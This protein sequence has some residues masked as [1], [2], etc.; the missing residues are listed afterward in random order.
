MNTDFAENKSG[1]NIFEAYCKALVNYFN[2]KGRTSRYDYWSFCLVNFLVVAF[3]FLFSLF[4]RQM[5]E[6][7]A[8][9]VLYLLNIYHLLML[10][11]GLSAIVRR[12]HDHNKSA[13]TWLLLPPLL[14]CVVLFVIGR[15]LDYKA[16]IILF[17]LVIFGLCVSLFV[18]LCLRGSEVDN[19][20]GPAII[21]T[22]DQRWKGLLIPVLVVVAPILFSFSLGVVS[23]YSRAIEKYHTNKVVPLMYDLLADAKGLKS[24][25]PIAEDDVLSWHEPSQPVGVFADSPVGG[26]IK[27]KRSGGYYIITHSEV[28][29][30]LCEAL[31][32][33]NWAEN[34]DF[35][36]MQINDGADCRSCTEQTPCTITWRYR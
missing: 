2:F 15:S 27:I 7:A 30:V 36:D 13:L 17:S 24:G 1:A 18:F 35:E 19:K 10:I 32:Q 12:F 28:S 33:Y 23:G 3:L 21:E 4:I 9:N 26:E 29:S 31:S 8:I 5:S 20:Y 11:P 6:Q 16:V 14:C 34:P 22:S 25:M